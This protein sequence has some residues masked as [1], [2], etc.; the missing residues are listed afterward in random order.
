MNLRDHIEDLA[1]QVADSDGTDFRGALR[2]I[3]TD[4]WHVAHEKGFDIDELFRGSVD[5][6]NEE[7]ELE[8][9]GEAEQE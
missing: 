1:S 5:V 4:I 7:L 9:E 8:L 2:D 6:F 3:L